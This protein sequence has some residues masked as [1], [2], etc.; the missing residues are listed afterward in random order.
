M[1][2]QVLCARSLARDSGEADQLLNP[3]SYMMPIHIR[4]IMPEMTIPKSRNALFVA[5]K[6]SSVYSW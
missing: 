1:G 2:P 4:Q 5:I 6:L 3:S